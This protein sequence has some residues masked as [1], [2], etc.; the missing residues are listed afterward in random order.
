MNPFLIRSVWLLPA[1]LFAFRATG[2]EGLTLVVGS[3]HTLSVAGVRQVAVG[4]A[5]VIKARV[6]PPS[7]VLLT[8]KKAG[9]S[10]VR[11]WTSEGERAWDVRV[12]PPESADQWAGSLA[13]SV[14]AV[15]LEF[16]EID[17]SLGRDIG[18][19]WPDTIQG[20]AKGTVS[21][22]GQLSG[23]NYTASFA[24]AQGLLQLLLR[25]GWAS[26]VARPELA[27]RFG[28][29]AHFHSGGEIPI[30]TSSGSYGVLHRRVE[31]KPYG[32]TVKVCPQSLDGIH[33]RASV[34][35]EVTEPA[36]A[37]ARDGVP[38]L[39]RRKLETKINAR[40]GEPL[41]LSG[42]IKQGQGRTREGIP[43][44]S[45][46]PL[47]GL[48]FSRRSARREDTELLMAIT[49]RLADSA[50]RTAA[51]VDQVRRH[52]ESQASDEKEPER[53]ESDP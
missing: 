26:V 14:V 48:L 13:Q 19:R 21:G 50:P 43:F 20:S 17:S 52:V 53:D 23:L 42:L 40:I 35:L 51:R 39:M 30:A 47:L 7:E 10:A 36:E 4:D 49:F 46:I 31:W 3:N 27:V 41:I 25:E 24:T 16:L 32:L 22:G 9:R 5:R 34:G 18:V 29:E 2:Q 37:A 6:V 28:E 33:L 44:L 15:S 8:A 11:V 38:G 45:A 12:I 1:A